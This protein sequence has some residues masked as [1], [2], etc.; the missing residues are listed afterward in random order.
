MKIRA[1]TNQLGLAPMR[2]PKTRAR[3]IDAVR[4][5]TH[6]ARH[7]QADAPSADSGVM[8]LSAPRRLP[9]L[10]NVRLAVKLGLSFGVILALT[11]AI[12]VADLVNLEGLQT[13]HE[14]V[15]Q[16]VVPQIMA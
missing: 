12:I 7:A 1:T 14:R 8:R 16:R 6:G 2:S 10:G 13:A 4:I 9:R 5:D 11:A 15:T 3:W